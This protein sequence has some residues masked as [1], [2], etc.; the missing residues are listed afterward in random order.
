MPEGSHLVAV[1]SKR[2]G[3]QIARPDTLL[4]AGDELLILTDHPDAQAI[5]EALGLDGG[6]AEPETAAGD[7]AE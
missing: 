7:A 5:R 3:L 6:A 1:I 4:L 2:N